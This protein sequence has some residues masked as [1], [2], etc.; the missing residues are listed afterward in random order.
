MSWRGRKVRQLRETIA[1]LGDGEC[2]FWYFQMLKRHEFQAPFAIKPELPAKS[3]LKAQFQRAVELSGEYDQVYWVVDLDVVLEEDRTWTK[4]GQSPLNEFNNMKGLLSKKHPNVQI[5]I[6]NPCL[7]Y[8]FLLHFEKIRG[9]FSHCDAVRKALL[10]HLPDYDK[11]KKYFTQ[12]TD[13]YQRLRPLL[14]E[15]IA[16]SKAIGN[17]NPELPYSPVAEIGALVEKLHSR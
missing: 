8:W 10:K 15:A 11:N 13:I 2:E 6:N 5:L 14:P 7:E 3:T 16:R 4:G 12:G 17:W 9:G 1:I